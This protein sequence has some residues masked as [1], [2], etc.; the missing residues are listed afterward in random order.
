MG[1]HKIFVVIGKADSNHA[2][3][4]VAH[5]VVRAECL[6]LHSRERHILLCTMALHASFPVRLITPLLLV[7]HN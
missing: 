3:I 5:Q 4:L 6:I 2:V 1:T 7:K